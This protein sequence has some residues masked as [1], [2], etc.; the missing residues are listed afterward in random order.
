MPPESPA[1]PA[2]C[3]WGLCESLVFGQKKEKVLAAKESVSAIYS[4]G[5][6]A[7]VIVHRDEDSGVLGPL[8]N[9]ISYKVFL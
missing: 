9:Y 6:S 8:S 1:L 4:L 7:S 3:Q 2:S 5:G